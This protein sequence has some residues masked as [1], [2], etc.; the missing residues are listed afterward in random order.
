[1]KS[2]FLNFS[3]VLL[4]ASITAGLLTLVPMAASAQSEEAS[5]QRGAMPDIT[6]KQRYD[7]A[8]REAGGGLKV[9]LK[10][11]RAM[12]AM[13]RKGCESQARARYRADMASAKAMLHDPSAR[14]YQVTG[15]PIR[16]T[17]TTYVVKP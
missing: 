12:A 3:T 6:P 5:L 2:S 1:M 16:S 4:A 14:P 17:E 11:C 8:I 9:S 13:D 10:E 7:T 15:E